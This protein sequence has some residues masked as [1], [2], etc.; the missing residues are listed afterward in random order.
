M[1]GIQHDDHGESRS[2]EEPPHP[3]HSVIVLASL[4]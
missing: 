4:K 3:R 2:S 1:E